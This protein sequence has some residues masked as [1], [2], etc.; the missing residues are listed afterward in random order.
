M[1][2]IRSPGGMSR[3]PV[4][5]R[6]SHGCKDVQASNPSDTFRF[7]QDLAAVAHGEVKLGL[8]GVLADPLRLP[9]RPLTVTL[10]TGA[11]Y[12]SMTVH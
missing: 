7:L 4:Y 11:G 1:A 9:Q 12:Q 6:R 5:P 8:T 3:C 10:P 2:G